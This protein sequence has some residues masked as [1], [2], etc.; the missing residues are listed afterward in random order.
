[1]QAAR[2][3][4]RS[5]R[6]L[7]QSLDPAGPVRR[8]TAASPALD[9]ERATRVLLQLSAGKTDRPQSTG[10]AG[11]RSTPR[12][13]GDSNEVALEGLG[14]VTTRMAGQV[15]TLTFSNTDW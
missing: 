5:G 13:Q 8:S 4:A 9:L 2:V 1:M 12:A 15:P 10:A 11:T 14:V 3:L 6:R 7:A